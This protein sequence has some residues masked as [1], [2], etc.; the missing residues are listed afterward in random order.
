M[1]LHGSVVLRQRKGEADVE[2]ADGGEAVVCQSW[3]DGGVKDEEGYTIGP[4]GGFL[5]HVGNGFALM[6]EE[7][8]SSE[9]RAVEERALDRGEDGSGFGICDTVVHAEMVRQTGSEVRDGKDG[10]MGTELAEEEVE[11]HCLVGDGGL[12]GWGG[13]GLHLDGIRAMA[14]ADGHIRR[15]SGGAVLS[16]GWGSHG[17]GVGKSVVG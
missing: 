2:G 1:G 11:R 4:F 13:K 9:V 7:P 8:D 10:L 3:S 15:G 17:G 14:D 6:I 12:D 16:G 5:A